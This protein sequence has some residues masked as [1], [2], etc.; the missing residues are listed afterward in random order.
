MTVWYQRKVGEY[1]V[2]SWG[3][4]LLG[5]IFAGFVLI[6]LSRSGDGKTAIEQFADA[7]GVPQLVSEDGHSITF[8]VKGSEETVGDSVDDLIC[9]S[10]FTKAPDNVVQQVRDTDAS[11]GVQT[12]KWDAFS[13]TWHIPEDGHGLDITISTE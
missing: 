7:C 9:I 5:V 6:V 4:I 8:D 12:A 13:A 10:V 11:D 3:L 2:W 1:R